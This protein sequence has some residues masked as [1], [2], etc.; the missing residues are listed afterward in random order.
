M[1]HPDLYR[2]VLM[3]LDGVKVVVRGDP[4]FCLHCYCFHAVGSPCCACG[5]PS[6]LPLFVDANARWVYP[7]G[8]ALSADAVP[9]L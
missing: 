3:D 9:H 5:S 6:L 7:P 1:T 4:R 8:S 2:Q